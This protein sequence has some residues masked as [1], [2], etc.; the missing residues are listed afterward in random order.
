M[1][2]KLFLTMSGVFWL[3]GLYIWKVFGCRFDMWQYW[4]TMGWAA[5]FFIIGVICQYSKDY[6]SYERL[7]AL[8]LEQKEREKE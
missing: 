6:N 7:T 4:T 2:Y 8:F 5:A 1:K 3:Y